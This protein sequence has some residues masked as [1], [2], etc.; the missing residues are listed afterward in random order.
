MIR[1]GL[2]PALFRGQVWGSL[3]PGAPILVLTTKPGLPSGNSAA[4]GADSPLDGVA[5]D[6]A[7]PGVTGRGPGQDEAVSVHI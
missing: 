5:E 2:L 3:F 1:H 7:A 4:Q 6:G